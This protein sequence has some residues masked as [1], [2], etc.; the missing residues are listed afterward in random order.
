[1]RR[2]SRPALPQPPS[3]AAG[4]IATSVSASTSHSAGSRPGQPRQ[5]Q[6]GPGAVVGFSTGIASQRADRAAVEI[7]APDRPAP[8]P[9]RDRA[10][11]NAA[12]RPARLRLAAS[13]ALPRPSAI[14]RGPLSS[15]G[16]QPFGIEQVEHRLAAGF[17]RKDGQSA[18]PDRPSGPAARRSRARSAGRRS[19]L[20]LEDQRDMVRR[21]FPAAARLQHAMRGGLRRKARASTTYGRAGGRDRSPPSPGRDSSTR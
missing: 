21:P 3:I 15:I 12:P 10:N 6:R 11:R 18:D 7:A 5:R 2:W 14:A 9:R 17:D 16:A 19:H 8:A 13:C 20:Q 4:S 1:M